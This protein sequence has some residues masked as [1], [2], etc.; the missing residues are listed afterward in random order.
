VGEGMPVG[1]RPDLQDEVPDAE[2]PVASLTA[3]ADQ[4]RA[5]SDRTVPPLDEEPGHPA[6]LVVP[7][8]NSDPGPPL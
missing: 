1:W 2:E 3:L 7:V 5:L 4:V 6:V 8:P